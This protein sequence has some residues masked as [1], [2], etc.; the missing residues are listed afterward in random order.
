MEIIEYD[1]NSV[2]PITKKRIDDTNFAIVSDTR[3][4]IYCVLDL[5]AKQVVKASAI[6]VPIRSIVVTDRVPKINK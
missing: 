2:N 3:A 4:S 1:F 6:D 5:A